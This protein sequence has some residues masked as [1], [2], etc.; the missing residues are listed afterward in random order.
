AVERD[1]HGEEAIAVVDGQGV[2]DAARSFD[3]DVRDG[4]QRPRIDDDTGIDELQVLAGRIELEQ[5]IAAGGAVH[6]GTD[7]GEGDVIAVAAHVGDA[8]HEAAAQEVR[9]DDGA[10]RQTGER[11]ADGVAGVVL[12]NDEYVAAGRHEAAER[13]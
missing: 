10:L 1:R 4:G 6:G 13:C 2:A 3:G 9:A 5:K 11:A 12:D 8:R 7:D